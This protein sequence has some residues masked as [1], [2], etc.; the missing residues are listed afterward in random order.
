MD[1]DDLVHVP[2]IGSE[3]GERRILHAIRRRM[4]DLD[5]FPMGDGEVFPVGAETGIAYVPFEVTAVDDDSLMDIDEQG[6]A[7]IVDRD[8]H[9]PVR[10]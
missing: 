8:Q 3:Q 10:R 6:V 2:G 4:P 7:V 5:V 1:V 9:V